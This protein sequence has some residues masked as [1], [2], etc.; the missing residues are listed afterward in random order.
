[1]KKL[2]FLG[3]LSIIGLNMNAQNDSDTTNIRLGSKKI[4]IVEDKDTTTVEAKNNDVDKYSLTYW[5]GLDL[6]VNML[7]T[8]DGSTTMPDEYN[9]LELDYTRSL[10]W[11]LNLFEKKARIIQDYVGIVTGV[12][13]TWNSYGLKNNVSLET[14]DSSATYAITIPDTV[15]NFTKNKLRASYVNVPLLL[16][17]NT[18]KNEDNNFHITAGVIGGWNMNTILKQK[19]EK[20][21]EDGQ[22]RRRN[23]FNMNPFTLDATARIG[24]K[25]FTLFAT[26]GLTPMFKKNKGPEV[27]PMTV[28]LQIIPW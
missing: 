24:Y 19:W 14:R 4:T 1:M 9:W 21:S 15:M 11:R 16:E 6:G 12:G 7:F 28:G 10:S 8:K 20:G 3:F 26:Y 18:S 22:L 5:G 17:F 13:F 23:D 2:L 27:Y 25:N